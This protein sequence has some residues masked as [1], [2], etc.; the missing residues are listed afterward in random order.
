MIGKGSGLINEAGNLEANQR[1]TDAVEYM[2]SKEYQQSRDLND[3]IPTHQHLLPKR[4]EPSLFGNAAVFDP[5]AEKE[6]AQRQ[7]D[8][9]EAGLDD[10][11]ELALLRERRL[12]A[13]KKNQEKMGDWLAKG[14]GSYR[15]I[16]QDDFFNV[17]VRDKGGS[18]QVVV[19]FYHK[20]FERCKIMDKH[21]SELAQTML[22]A[23]FVKVNVEKAPF[24]VDKLRVTVLPCLIIFNNDIA[25]DRVVGFDE[26]GAGDEFETPVLRERIE[27]G[28]NKTQK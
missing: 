5:K 15:E 1:L 19:H 20:D 12:A 23:R 24:L 10:D 25:V 16:A 2:Q 21:L 3:V 27:S 6:E 7:R 18:D 17:V 4:K 14:H 9:A 8:A 11:D 13:M 22:S 26:L 28:I